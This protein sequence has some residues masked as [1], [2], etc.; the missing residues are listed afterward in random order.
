MDTKKPLADRLRPTTLCEV[1]GQKHLIGP[2]KILSSLVESGHVPNLIFYGP[3]GIGKTTIA[4]IIASQT[5]KKFYKLNA[6]TATTADIKAM[7]DEV[8]TI[9]APNGIL[10]YLDE[11]QYFNKKQQQTLL[12]FLET[13][14]ITMIAST[15]ENPYFYIYN[16]ILSRCTVFE[17]QPLSLKDIKKTVER[18][19][20]LL[21]SE[22]VILR[23]S[24]E[25]MDFLCAS[26]GGD[27]RKALNALDVLLASSRMNEEGKYFITLEQ[28]QQVSQRSAMRYDRDADAHFDIL[29]AL[30]KSIRGSDTDAALHYLARL[31]EAGDLISPCRRI[32]AAASE[33]IGLAYPLVQVVVKSCIDSAFQLGL[34]EARLP[35][36]EAVILLCTAP[37]SNSVILAI[38]AAMADVKAGKTG[39]IPS[40]LK[41]GHYQGAQKL[42]HAIGYEYP[43]NFPNHYTPQQY[44]PEEL[45]GVSYYC[46][47][48]N[49]TEQAARQYWEKIKNVK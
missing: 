20:T 32:L 23:F 37:K 12:E 46:Y 21:K 48:D 17:F 13:G 36:A 35:L 41:D 5:K 22:G 27:A 25:V 2:G 14:K 8:D 16:A 33:D 19:L 47:G 45:K 7:L 44:L 39:D 34:P 3:S 9:L 4:G 1:A 15:T 26:C 38:D 29:S 30:H 28:A 6:T 43:H 31:L 18:A 11:I 49:K 40:H 24:E 10:L 42:G